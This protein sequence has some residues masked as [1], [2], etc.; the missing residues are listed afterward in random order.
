MVA[1]IIGLL[2][3]DADGV[4]RIELS[5]YEQAERACKEAILHAEHGVA[6]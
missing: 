6:A 5:Q 4:E 1:G 2:H 3:R